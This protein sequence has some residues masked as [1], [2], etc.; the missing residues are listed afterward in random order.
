MFKNL[1]KS[2]AEHN[3]IMLFV[4][5][6][7]VFIFVAGCIYW[8]LNSTFNSFHEE[9]LSVQRKL[10]DSIISLQEEIEELRADVAILKSN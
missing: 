8:S 1:D 9:S 5:C 6:V 7:V 10:H 4:V 3:P 2:T